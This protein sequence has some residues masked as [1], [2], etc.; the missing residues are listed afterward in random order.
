MYV[1]RLVIALTMRKLALLLL[2][3]SVLAE[4]HDGYFYPRPTPQ[5]FPQV[6]TE[7]VTDV[8]TETLNHFFTDVNT[9]YLTD[10]LTSTLVNPVYITSTEYAISTVFVPRVELLTSTLIVQPSPVVEYVRETVFSTVVAQADFGGVAHFESEN[11]YLPPLPPQPPP[12]PPPQLNPVLFNNALQVQQPPAFVPLPQVSLPPV[13]DHP[14]THHPYV[15]FDDGSSGQ[16][17]LGEPIGEIGQQFGGGGLVGGVD[18]LPHLGA[19]PPAF[20]EEGYRYKRKLDA[21]SPRRPSKAQIN[22]ST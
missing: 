4:P 5:C 6:Y 21:S 1:I 22:R 16:R 14:V 10:Y 12:P 18:A 11:T 8:A 20:D 13:L 9:V 3:G 17:S 15:A 2:I 19:L 7:T